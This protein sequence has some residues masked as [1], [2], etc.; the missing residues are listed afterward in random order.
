MVNELGKS[1]PL[2]SYYSDREGGPISIQGTYL[3]VP[4]GGSAGSILNI[5]GGIFSWSVLRPFDVAI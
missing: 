2:Q 4:S 1:I 3:F 5:P